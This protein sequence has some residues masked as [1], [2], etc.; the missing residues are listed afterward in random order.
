MQLLICADAGCGFGVSIRSEN[1]PCLTSRP[2]CDVAIIEGIDAS[3]PD[4]YERIDY[5]IH[6]GTHQVAYFCVKRWKEGQT[7]P[8]ITDICF[9]RTD[10]PPRVLVS[11]LRA[12]F[13]RVLPL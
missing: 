11:C 7:E 10:A 8:A 12:Y 2:F 6:V 13:A 9:N 4:G 5:N 3:V 1:G